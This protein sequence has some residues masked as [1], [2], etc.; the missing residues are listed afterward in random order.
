MKTKPISDKDPRVTRPLLTVREAAWNLAIAESTF[1]DWARGY[2]RSAGRNAS[3][4][5]A[6]VTALPAK[7][8]EATIPF[9][10]LV[11]GL[12]LAAFRQTGI[13]LQRIRPALA[14][15]AR[16]IGLEHALASK[17]LYSDGA[18]VLY[19]Y[20]ERGREGLDELA[21]SLVV[22]R[23]GQ[24]VFVDVVRDY[25]KLIHFASDGWPDRVSLPAYR[26]AKVIVDPRFAFGRPIFE[27]G[28]ARVEDVLDRWRAGESTHELAEDFGVPA[29]EI[30]DAA[31]AT[32][33]RAAA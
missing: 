18:E 23:S 20:A 25:L 6:V 15:L 12:V 16:E 27:H 31:R 4:G 30:E 32:S 14:I 2:R 3:V 17:G 10:G 28:G 24:H 29:S 33:I 21:E 8:R 5:E 11:E 9:I 22:V 13:P 26:S 1:R 19:S 7:G